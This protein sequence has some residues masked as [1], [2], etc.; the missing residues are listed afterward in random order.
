MRYLNNA[1]GLWIILLVKMMWT[2]FMCLKIC[3]LHLMKSIVL[4]AQMCH[5]FLNKIADLI[6]IVK[7]VLRNKFSLES[8]TIEPLFKHLD[9]S[10]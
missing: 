3:V 2:K 6:D 5:I 10:I 1:D 7:F 9:L 4:S 8:V